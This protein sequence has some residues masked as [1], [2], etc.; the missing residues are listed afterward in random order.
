[1]LQVFDAPAPHGDR[2]ISFLLLE[3]LKHE[4][5]QKEKEKAE[6]KEAETMAR[7]A[8]ESLLEV[9]EKCPVAGFS[10]DPLN[11][12]WTLPLLGLKESA[13]RWSKCGS[14]PPYMC[15]A[16]DELWSRSPIFLFLT[17]SVS[18]TA[19]PHN[20]WTLSLFNLRSTSPMFPACSGTSSASGSALKD[21]KVPGDFFVLFTKRKMCEGGTGVETLLECPWQPASGR[22][23]MP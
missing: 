2:T 21:A 23:L 6:E 3:A 16:L 17:W 18:S 7:A 1:M 12:V 11:K 19:P 22:G 4:H 15:W 9:P 8:L 20:L 5:W 10:N 13:R 14:S